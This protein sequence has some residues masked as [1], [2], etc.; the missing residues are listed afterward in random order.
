LKQI[1]SNET[2]YGRSSEGGTAIA[3]EHAARELRN[4]PAILI[5]GSLMRLV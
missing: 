5:I 3:V 2:A 1:K 4:G